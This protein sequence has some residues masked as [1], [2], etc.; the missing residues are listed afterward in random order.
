MEDREFKEK[1]TEYGKLFQRVRNEVSKTLV[2]QKEI[3]DAILRAIVSNGHV[4]VEGVPGVAKTLMLRTISKVI[5]CEFS[6]IQFTADLLPT[7]IVGITA[8]EESRGFYVIKGPIFANFVLADEVNRAPPKVQSALLEAMAEHQSTIGK[9]TFPLP[10][11]FFVMATQNPLESLGTYELPEAQLDRFLFKTFM[12]YPKREEEKIILETNINTSSFEDYD[13]KT[14]LDK[15]MIAQVQKDVQNVYANDKIKEYIVTLIDATRRPSDYKFKLSKYIDWG[16]SPRAS[17]GLFI[18]SKAEAL[19]KGRI[20]VIPS[21]VKSVAHDVLRH[22]I[23]ISYEGQ[24]EGITTD[25]ILDELL[26]KIPIP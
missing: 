24:S 19:I 20:F 8:Y 13:L 3:I 11:P 12:N 14:V 4:L 17:I 26:K 16:V 1:V 5:G 7:D 21:D 22:R 9:E 18:A 6:R 23:L 10:T 15:V 25:M 2:G